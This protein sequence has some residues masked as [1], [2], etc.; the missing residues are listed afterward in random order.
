M[1][2]TQERLGELLPLAYF[3]AVFTLPQ[4]V[5]GLAL[6]NKGVMYNLLF[7]AASE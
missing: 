1:K 7:R 3:H 4:I 6:Q 5:A 2:W